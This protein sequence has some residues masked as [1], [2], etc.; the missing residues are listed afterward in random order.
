M[1]NTMFAD[2]Q[3]GSEQP[4]GESRTNW[5]AFAPYQP[6]V[7]LFAVR[8]QPLGSDLADARKQTRPRTLYFA[9]DS[10]GAVQE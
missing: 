2:T 8:L 3:N 1:F 5:N 7:I 4:L 10:H 6:E 9:T